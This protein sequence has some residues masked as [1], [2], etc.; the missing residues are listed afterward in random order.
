[1]AYQKLGPF[2][3]VRRACWKD[4]AV[5]GGH[6]ASR[7]DRGTPPAT[8]ATLLHPTNNPGN[9]PERRFILA[10]NV[11][12]GDLG[13]SGLRHLVPQPLVLVRAMPDLPAKL[14]RN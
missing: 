5:F 8:D 14:P 2:E 13:A 7:S 10:D 12:H 11:G 1:M 6:G 9:A 3:Q 4:R